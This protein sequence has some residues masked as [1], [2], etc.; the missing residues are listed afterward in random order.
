M[1]TLIGQALVFIVSAVVL[2]PIFRWLRLGSV[3]GYLMAGLIVGPFG[4]QL[5]V[6]SDSVINFA[7]LGIVLLLFLIGLEIQP[8][9]LWSMRRDLF[10]LG[11]FQIIFSSIIFF[12]I[13]RAF[14]LELLSAITI[15]FA[16]S[17]SST[18]FA[19]QTLTERKQFNSE[20]GRASFSILLMQDLVA[21]PALALIPLLT[22]ADKPSSISLLGSASVIILII[23]IFLASRYL[24]RPLFRIIAS[25]RAQEIFTAATLLIVLGVAQLMQ[26]VGLSAALGTF[27]AGVLLADS[28]YRH[29][30]EANLEPF[31]NLL[32]G[33]FFI[34]VGMSVH[35]DLFLTEPVLLFG[36]T[37]SYLLLKF[38]SI[39][40]AG[41]LFKIN[42]QNSTRMALTIIQGGEFAFVIFSI[43]LHSNQ[44]AS[45][46]LALLTALITLS[47]ALSPLLVLAYDII[48]RRRD[49]K[50]QPNYDE[51]A[52]EFPEV[53]IAGFGRFGQI[54][55]RILRAQNIPFVAIDHNSE[56][57]ELVRR[58]GNKV[59]FGDASRKE[60][61]VAAGVA[62]AKYFI[63][64][65]DDVDASTKIA[66]L[67]I[68][69]FPQIKVFARARNRGHAFDLMALGISRIK[70]ET[71][72]SS[73]YFVRD[74]L[75][76][77][78]FNPSQAA[79]VVEK[80]KRHDELMLVEQFKVRDDDK[81]FINLSKQSTAQ[82][83]QVLSNE[84]N[85]SYI[86]SPK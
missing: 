7:D 12:L 83:A 25:S 29:E 72:D 20:F 48:R 50:L 2:V 41:R 21:I 16:L 64:C 71:L 45:D 75:V 79:E 15:G 42:H 34:G 65:I 59:Y 74:L 11:L 73:V 6:N 37:L 82:L 13:A 70:R 8:R 53:I 19:L 23:L 86:D 57:I 81:N 54:F 67:L 5:I 36:L 63:L 4:F 84:S 51:I 27:I 69:N 52:N 26:S 1:T 47:M 49:S 40:A 77:M 30:L 28:E 32:M 14:G 58:H 24:M 60:L 17:L 85:Q 10:G 43:I 33:L 18:A 3:L 66:E 80:F 44:V 56:Q 78:G 61:L 46:T 9:K 22:A 31:K 35:L 39:Y 55:G 68:E 38:L 62:H 76:E